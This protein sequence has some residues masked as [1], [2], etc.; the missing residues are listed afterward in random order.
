M[1]L[2]GVKQGFKTL[3]SRNALLIVAFYI[4]NM[5]STYFKNGYRSLI[6]LNEAEQTATILGTLISVFLITGLLTRGPAGRA[7]DKMGDKLKMLVIIISVLKAFSCVLYRYTTTIATLYISFIL[8]GVVWA[9][10][11]VAAPA[12]LAKSVD[13]KAMGSAYAIFEGLMTIITASARSLGGKFFND[14]GNSSRCVWIA[15]GIQMAAVLLVIFLDGKKLMQNVAPI[16]NK[17]KESKT[18]KGF[19]SLFGLSMAALPFAVMVGSQYFVY[20]MES[21]FAVPYAAEMGLDYVTPATLGGTIYGILGIVMGFVCDFVSPMVLVIIA[22]VGQ[23]GAMFVLGS[24]ATQSVFAAG[25]LIFYTTRFYLFPLRIVALK[26]APSSESG[27]VMGTMLFAQDLISIIA[28]TVLG[29]FIDKVGY[30]AT[31]T[32]LGVWGSLAVV[33]AIFYAIKINKR[34]KLQS[35]LA[36]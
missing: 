11:G 4:L 23:A 8:D 36:D 27:S 32:G 5:Y 30:S 13:K 31:F 12:L 29:F 25:I 3:L 22:F 7:I 34:H 24:A 35:S 20:N 10:I 21:N 19:L 9:F 14:Y 6:V 17:I 18:K 2:S 33:F 26:E 1:D 16:K 28:A 15:F